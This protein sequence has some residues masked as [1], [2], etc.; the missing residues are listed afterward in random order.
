MQPYAKERVSWPAGGSIPVA[1]DE[2]LPA[3]DVD[4]LGCWRQK[5]LRP[6]ADAQALRTEACPRGP[7]CDPSLIRSPR[8]YADFLWTLHHAGM[9]RWERSAAVGA[10]NVGVFFALKSDG[11]SLRL[12]F[13]TRTANCDY[14]APPS[15][16]L[17]TAA[18]MGNLECPEGDMYLC[19]GDIECAFYRMRVPAGMET[20]FRLPGLAA[21]HL[22]LSSVGGSIV[23]A[24]DLITPCLAVLPMGWSWALHICQAMLRSAIAEAGFRDE[25][26]VVDGRP[27]VLLR[28]EEDTAVAGYVDN[29]TVASRSPVAA[30]RGRD[31]IAS[32]LTRHRLVVH[33]LEEPSSDGPRFVGLELARGRTLSI[34][35]RGLWK[36]AYGLRELLRRGRCSGTVLRAVVGHLTWAVLLRR[37]ALAFAQKSY[38]FVDAAGTSVRPL[39]ASVRQELTDLLALLPLLRADVGAVWDEVVVCSDASPFGL[40]VCTK[41]IGADLAGHVGRHLE[42]WRYKVTGAAAARSRALGNDRLTPDSHLDRESGDTFGPAIGDDAP[43]DPPW[44]IDEDAGPFGRLGTSHRDEPRPD[45]FDPERHDGGEQF[46]RAAPRAFDEVP[47]SVWER[48]GWVTVHASRVLGTHNILALEGEALHRAFK[49]ALRSLRVHGRRVLFLVDNLPL[50]MAVAKG[51]AKS[52]LLTRVLLKISA[53]SLAT[54]TRMV[55]RWIPSEFNAADDPSRGKDGFF[56]SPAVGSADPLDAELPEGPPGLADVDDGDAEDSDE[57]PRSL[58]PDL[59]HHGA[60]DFRQLR[61]VQTDSREPRRPRSAFAAPLRRADVP[62]SRRGAP[63]YPAGDLGPVSAVSHRAQPGSG[64]GGRE[65]RRPRPCA[66]PP[67]TGFDLSQR[68]RGL[69]L[70]CGRPAG[71]DAGTSDSDTG[72]RSVDLGKGRTRTAVSDTPARSDAPPEASAAADRQPAASPGRRPRARAGGPRPG[73]SLQ[74]LTSLPRG[75]SSHFADGAGKERLRRRL[76][77][78]F[79]AARTQARASRYCVFVE[80]FTGSRGLAPA[81]RHIGYGTVTL[82]PSKGPW[83]DVTNPTVLDGLRGWVQSGAVLGV[84]LSPPCSTWSAAARPGYRSREHLWGIPGQSRARCANVDLGSE[85]LRVSVQLVRLCRRRHVPVFLEHPRN[86]L[87]WQVPEVRELCSLAGAQELDYDACLYGARWRKG[88]KTVAWNAGRFAFS[89]RRCSGRLGVCSHTGKRHVVLTGPSPSGPLW[90]SIAATLPPQL[91][92]ELAAALDQLDRDRKWRRASRI[93]MGTA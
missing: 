42:R 69:W 61:G 7:Y 54:G 28:Q 29:F 70:G 10:A 24:D 68:E 50:A 91:C 9:L 16:R 86:S 76:H 21:R 90:T 62:A 1:L 41:V 64:R 46:L 74:P 23:G 52:P 3:A 57:P 92:H 15:T 43:D 11:R 82:D 63:V 35:R 80:P 19:S 93:C 25:Q 22:G 36:L 5:L 48:T 34:K 27:G 58:A 13:D 37:E 83:G 17:P 77:D 65:P 84:W 18:A 51:R 53:L 38:A 14:V 55:V 33:E 45:A 73:Q 2:I 4:W 47:S 20:C 89:A 8:T 40:G 85:T 56:A 26:V 81:L 49:H 66:A 72:S 39:W 88:I 12:I 71:D 44:T 75:G 32:V 31:A 6:S 59:G 79:R 30:R 87:V 78:A 60:D 67:G